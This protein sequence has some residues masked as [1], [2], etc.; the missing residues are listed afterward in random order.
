MI[1]CV[2]RYNLYI[3]IYIYIYI[4][5]LPILGTVEYADVEVT[6]SLFKT[7]IDYTYTDRTG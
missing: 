3:Y 6:I 4:I 2:L 7:G 5:L 1:L